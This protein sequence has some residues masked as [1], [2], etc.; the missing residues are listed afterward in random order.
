MLCSATQPTAGFVGPA[1]T[2]PACGRDG[3]LTRASLRR[4]SQT[5]LARR[6]CTACRHSW[7]AISNSIPE[8]APGHGHAVA[9]GFRDGALSTT[10]QKPH[11][12]SLTLLTKYAQLDSVDPGSA[13][14][15][16]GTQRRP[17]RYFRIRTK[18]ISPR[19]PVSRLRRHRRRPGW[20]RPRSFSW[21]WPAIR[22]GSTD[23]L[24]CV[25][26]SPGLLV[27]GS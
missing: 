18:P 14:Q 26:T 19:R 21:W 9:G 4:R 6:A 15:N 13:T 25:S 12:A 10:T 8:P 5:W 3:G 24:P 7:D 1:Q 27:P 11:K 23:A 2:D 20:F 16:A 22:P 17:T